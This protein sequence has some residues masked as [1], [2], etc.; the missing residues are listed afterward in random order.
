MV[1]Y[2]IGGMF[3]EIENKLNEKLKKYGQ[4]HLLI[5]YNKFNEE[6]KS[7]LIS[8]LESIDFEQIQNLYNNI[9]KNEEG[10]VEISP[11]NCIEKNSLT[12]EEK[13]KYFAMGAE[14]IK[15][16]K[17]AVVTMAGGQGTRLGHNGPKGTFMLG[18]NPD[19]SLF[20]ILCDNFKNA[21]EKYGVDIPWYIMTSK[22]NNE[23]TV[24]FFEKNNY[25]NY[26]KDYVKF[27][28]QGEIP[29]IDKEG[30][31]L[32]DEYGFVKQAS[33][34]HGGIFEAMFKN[35][36]VEDMKNKN[37]EWIFIGPIDNPLAKLV[38][39]I[40]IGMAKSN[41]VVEAGKSLVKANPKEKVGVF[42]KKNGKPSVIEY[43]EITEEMA[44]LKDEN[45]NLAYGESHINCNLFNI[46]GIE[47]IGATPLPYHTAFKKANYLDK[48]GN[49]IQATEPNCYKFESFIFDAFSI[50]DDMLI[51]RVNR[52]EE[53]APVKNA[54]G[55]DSPETA[56]E[57]YNKYF[58]K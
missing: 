2:Y 47:Q 18:I 8:E 49:F 1:T 4:E 5:N 7:K 43:T 51:Y 23:Q 21:K 37:V 26:N 33:N 6:Q 16:G 10:D 57:L 25:F 32:L 38:D 15:K 19:K 29:M 31:I 44:E 11:I 22:E 58:N 24:E 45:G 40:F 42:C 28:I 36:V 55:V 52:E 30:K 46:K 56:R 3:V 20:E 34:G 17:L 48:D 41:N 53:F 14:E 27:F 39:E 54:T 12:E 13:N 9:D 50:L 35:N